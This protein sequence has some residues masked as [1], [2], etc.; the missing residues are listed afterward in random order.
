MRSVMHFHKCDPFLSQGEDLALRA[1]SR[2]TGLEQIASHLQL[3]VLNFCTR[4]K[5]LTSHELKI[6][7][8]GLSCPC[9]K[10]F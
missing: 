2:V 10:C 8:G 1:D 5:R 7:V 3:Y 6:V 9:Q 4:N